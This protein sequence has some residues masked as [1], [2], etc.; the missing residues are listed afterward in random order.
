MQLTKAKG[1]RTTFT[2][3]PAGRLRCVF[4]FTTVTMPD[5]C[6][7]KPVAAHTDYSTRESILI[8]HFLLLN[9]FLPCIKSLPYAFFPFTSPLSFVACPLGRCYCMYR[10]TRGGQPAKR[11]GCTSTRA[12]LRARSWECLWTTNAA[13]NG[14]VSFGGQ[15]ARLQA[16]MWT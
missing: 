9:L 10:P 4:D 6:V 5:I 7:C 1:C 11:G 14:K 3:L 15:I 12:R 16:F 13:L 8:C 2:Q